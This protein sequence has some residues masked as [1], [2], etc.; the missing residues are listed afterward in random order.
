ME[1]LVCLAWPGLHSGM[2]TCGRKG[3]ASVDCWLRV[4]ELL[5]AA[6]V[7]AFDGLYY[8]VVS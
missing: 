2:A 7:E 1:G 5:A 3:V 4:G 6:L 8:C